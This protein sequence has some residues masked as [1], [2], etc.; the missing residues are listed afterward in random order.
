MGGQAGE[1]VE[2]VAYV[3]TGFSGG[4]RTRRAFTVTKADA[5]QQHENWVPHYQKVTTDELMAVAQHQRITAA[6]AAEVGRLQFDVATL[7]EAKNGLVEECNS[8]HDDNAELRHDRDTLRAELAEVNGREAVPVAH[9]LINC[10]GEVITE[11]KDGPPPDQITSA[12][13][14]V[15]TDVVLESAYG[16]PPASPDVEGLVNEL[17]R[18]AEKCSDPDTT[19]ALDTALSTWRQAQEGK[20]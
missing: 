1:E 11:W 20:P 14:V 5:N 19:D 12:C 10:L 18:I 8:L 6:M 13:G 3:T 9:R 16:L 17:Q 7:I 4:P 15:Q 2:V